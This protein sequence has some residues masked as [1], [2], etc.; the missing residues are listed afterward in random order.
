LVAFISSCSIFFV[1]VIR[2]VVLGNNSVFN[3][4]NS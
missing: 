3:R 4:A 1:A 2:V